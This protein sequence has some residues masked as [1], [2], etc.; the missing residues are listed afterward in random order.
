MHVK[1]TN[2][3]TLLQRRLTFKVGTQLNDLHRLGTGPETF[4]L[5]LP[6]TTCWISLISDMHFLLLEYNSQG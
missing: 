4:F 3:K 2:Y 1:R 5:I 6:P